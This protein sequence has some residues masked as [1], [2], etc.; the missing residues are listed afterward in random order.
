ME[1][2]IHTCQW[3][4]I[5]ILYHLRKIRNILFSQ[6]HTTPQYLL[7]MMTQ[8]MSSI[9]IGLGGDVEGGNGSGA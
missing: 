2:G 9:F 3:V 8:L 7:G 4:R 6:M 5:N 1:H